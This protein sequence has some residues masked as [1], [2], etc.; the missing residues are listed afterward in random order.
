MV[1]V[2]RYVHHGLS[3]ADLI[4][5]G[6]VG[7]MRAVDKYD[8]RQGNRFSTYAVWWIRLAITRALANR[9][10]PIRL[11]VHNGMLLP[12]CILPAFRR[13]M[14]QKCPAFLPHGLWRLHRNILLASKIFLNRSLRN[15]SG[16]SSTFRK[17]FL[18][19]FY[20]VN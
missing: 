11:P 17:N 15:I 8:Y 3:L 13:K 7:L 5:E 14:Q 6:N 10:R 1:V 20:R 2:K 9:S 18:S 19:L 16:K 4:Q 12:G